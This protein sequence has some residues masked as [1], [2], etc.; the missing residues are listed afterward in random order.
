[1]KLAVFDLEANG[2]DDATIIWCGA[3]KEGEYMEVYPHTK[4]EEI[5]TTLQA[6]D[7]IVGH[8]IIGYD[9]PLMERLWGFRYEGIAVDT[10]VMSKLL[11]PKRLGGHGL[12]AWGERVGIPK[13][14]HE[15]WGYYSS[16]MLHRCIQDVEINTKVLHILLEE[17]GMNEDELA[18][19]PKY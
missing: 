19:L 9:L 4:V 15:E 14:V 16:E 8:N 18:T 17:A 13:P 6:C 2:L 3:V 11:Q 1:M 5:I 10:L 12:A 7:I